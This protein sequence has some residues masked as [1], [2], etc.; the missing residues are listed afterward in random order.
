MLT[1]K[2]SLSPGGHVFQATGT[3]FELVQ[4]IIGTNRPTNFHDDLT[5][6][7]ASIEK[8]FPPPGGQVFQPTRT[9]FDLVPDIIGINL[10]TQFYEDR[11]INVASRVLTR[12]MLATQDGKM[13]SQKLTMSAQRS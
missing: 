3:I 7:V 11:T 9:I 6:N 1:R 2:N 8:N 10:L 13:R 12:Q 4:D 5:I